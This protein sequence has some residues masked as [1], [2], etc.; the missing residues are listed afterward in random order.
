[1]YG[2]P[3]FVKRITEAGW[4]PEGEIGKVGGGWAPRLS[5]TASP[6]KS[7]LLFGP[8]EV[9]ARVLARQSAASPHEIALSSSMKEG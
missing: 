8:V 5:S 9:A 1:M 6:R 2:R 4:R 7:G 3:V